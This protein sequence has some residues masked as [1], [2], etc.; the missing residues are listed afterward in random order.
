MTLELDESVGVRL[1]TTLTGIWSRIRVQHPEVPPVV[2]VFLARGNRTRTVGHFAALRWRVR[3]GD[4]G[5]MHEVCV[6][7][8]YLYRAAEDVLELLL[9]EAAHALNFA[10]GVHDCSSTSQYHNRRFRDAAV[11]LGLVVTNDHTYGFHSTTLGPDTAQAYAAEVESLR[12]ALLHRERQNRYWARPR[13]ENS[14]VAA[15]A[16]GY[17]VRASKKTF[18]ATTLMCNTCGEPFIVRDRPAGTA[19]K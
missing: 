17:R 7:T 3:D 1:I 12:E 13:R 4:D 11:E 9:H 8:E 19:R 14:I 15:C 10:R 5:L 16:C 6:T 18:A 2:V